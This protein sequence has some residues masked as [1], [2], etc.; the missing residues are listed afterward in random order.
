MH[1]PEKIVKQD[2]TEVQESDKDFAELKAKFLAMDK[3]TMKWILVSIN[4]KK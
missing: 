2:G 3:S 4:P 1:W